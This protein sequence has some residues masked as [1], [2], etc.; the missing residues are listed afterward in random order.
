MET[1]APHA[2]I[3]L[4]VLAVIGA[5]FGFVYWLNNAGGLGQREVYTVRFE[6]TVS[7]LLTGAAVQFNGIRV[8]EVTALRLD[9]AH[10][11][12][13]TA[14][15]AVAAGTPVRADTK[16][17]LDFQG[18]TGV[19]VVTLE[20]GSKALVAGP[21]GAPP[22]LSA[23]PDAG[24]SMTRAAREALLKLQKILAENSDP[25]HSAIVNINTFAAA[26]ARNSNR[27]DGI[28]KGLER[29]TG[30]APAAAQPVSYDLAP[31]QTFPAIAKPLPG[32]MVVPEPTTVLLYDTQK[33]LVRPSGGEG[34]SFE[35]ARWADSLPKLIQA[36]VVQSFENA[37]FLGLV[38][39]PIDGLTP[40]Y[41]LLIDLRRF[42]VTVADNQ[43]VADIEFSAKI[44]E[45]GGKIVGSRLFQA[46][47]PTK[48]TEAAA[49]AASLN[50]A[51]QKAA[52]E[53]VV[54]TAAT[55]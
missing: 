47:A 1:R 25:L 13:V 48:L 16:V 21:G 10:P 29:L 27:V 40:K 53:L 39:K 37:K 52:T 43:P 23:D 32:P 19:P 36:R 7:G 41:Q 11:R 35:H 8:G 24:Q 42:Q 22:V 12:Q 14:T 9:S 44:M 5:G 45:E 51:F 20:G 55:I 34:P 54:W 49:A 31:A 38:T 17:G 50:Q 4:F 33:I 3:G 2:L 30:G 15:I 26:L 28:L 6:S 18:L 46:S